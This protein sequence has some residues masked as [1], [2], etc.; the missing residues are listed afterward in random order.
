MLSPDNSDGV[1]GNWPLYANDAELE[2]FSNLIIGQ[3]GMTGTVS[4]APL[5]INTLQ[6]RA[7]Q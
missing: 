2:E 4:T 6:K 1:K 3:V 7:T 5:S